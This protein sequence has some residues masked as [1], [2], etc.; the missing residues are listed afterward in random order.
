MLRYLYLMGAILS[1]S[2]SDPSKLVGSNPDQAE[3]SNAP[4]A[5]QR[6]S[7][8]EPEP[9][10]IV[11]EPVSIAGAF[12]SCQRSEGSESAAMACQIDEAGIQ[13]GFGAGRVEMLN[14]YSLADDRA[15]A[16]HPFTFP[17]ENSLEF[18]LPAINTMWRIELVYPGGQMLRDWEVSRDASVNNLLEDGDF[19]AISVADNATDVSFRIYVANG[20]GSAWTATLQEDNNCPDMIPVFELNTSNPTTGEAAKF[21]QQFLDLDGGCFTDPSIEA[22]NVGIEQD[23]ELTAGSLYLLDFWYNARNN[24][25]KSMGMEVKVNGDTLW[26]EATITYQADWRRGKLIFKAQVDRVKVE[27]LEI[28]VSD[29]AGTALD[30]IRVIAIPAG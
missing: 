30:G 29:R 18:E 19:E 16:D 9:D 8:E 4:K 28:G 22:G 27:F 1:F 20:E 23:L 15:F 3:E 25:A 10:T 24:P 7:N 6:T 17:N 21:G 12:L 14:L 5:V 26:Q 13:A 11:S 2:C